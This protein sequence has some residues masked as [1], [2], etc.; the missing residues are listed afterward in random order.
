MTTIDHD[1]DEPLSERPRSR[2]WGRHLFWSGLILIGLL[3]YEVTAQPGL[4]VAVACTKF[5]W[6][7][8]LTARWLWRIDPNRRRGR[9]CGFLYVA[10]GFWKIALTGFAVI[11]IVAILDQPARRQQAAAAGP[12]P[13]FIGAGIATVVGFGTSTLFTCVALRSAWRSR[14][15][16]WLSPGVHGARREDLWPSLHEPAY[17][18]TNHAHGVILTA[19]VL[20]YFFGAVVLGAV[21]LSVCAAGGLMNGT[22]AAIVGLGLM[23]VGP[24]LL[25]LFNDALQR[26]VIAASPADCWSTAEAEDWLRY[27]HPEPAEHDSYPP[28]P[29]DG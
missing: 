3:V 26:R 4:G 18:G 25:L 6:N 21:I 9:A 1:L 23:F 28:F 13:E 22:L 12:P 29:E 10:S 17:A 19:L 8:F 7:D 16:L 20:A 11:W 24:V 2:R 5:G 27:T 14:V 15:K